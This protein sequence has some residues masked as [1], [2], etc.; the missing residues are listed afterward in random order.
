MTREPPLLRKLIFYVTRSIS[1]EYRDWATER[2]A[3]P[4]WLWLSTWAGLL[5]LEVPVLLLLR[6]FFGG[7]SNDGFIIGWIVIGLF[8]R[9]LFAR[10]WRESMLVRLE[11]RWS[12]EENGA[13]PSD[14]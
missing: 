14:L 3:A 13:V 10:G 2:I 12:K 5:F 11:K 1:V 8:I 9:P 7:P 4:S 6:T